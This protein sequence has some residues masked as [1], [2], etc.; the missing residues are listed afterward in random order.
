MATLKAR[1]TRNQEDAIKCW[2][3]I[4]S[5]ILGRA[6]KDSAG[7][8]AYRPGTSFDDFKAAFRSKR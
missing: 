3:E 1:A 4:G 6:N 8:M 2:D 5:V 7:D